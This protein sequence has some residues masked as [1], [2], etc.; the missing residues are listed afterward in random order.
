MRVGRN[1]KAFP[2][3]GAMTQE[4]RLAM[5]EKMKAA[6]DILIADEAYGGQYYSLTPGHANAI[7]DDK[8]KQLAERKNHLI[9]VDL[10]MTSGFYDPT[11]HR[12]LE[13]AMI[14]TDKNGDKFDSGF[15][16]YPPGHA[17][18]S[19]HDLDGILDHKNEMLG[20]ICV[21][22]IGAALSKLNGLRSKSPAEIKD[23]YNIKMKEQPPLEPESFT[24]MKA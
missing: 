20:D 21:A 10:E 3:P 8:Y 13:A 5:E 6:F 4:D 24:G 19:T 2:L 22:D 11:P 1:L 15:V 16:M 23:I 18:N 7:D 17:R 14:I 9:F 12:I